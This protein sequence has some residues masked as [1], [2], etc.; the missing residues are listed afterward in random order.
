MFPSV[1]LRLG[2]AYKFVMAARIR[3]GK[4]G[5]DGSTAGRGRV[6]LGKEYP[7]LGRQMAFNSIC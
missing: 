5:M 4:E 7:G 1:W 6:V 3:K 2:G